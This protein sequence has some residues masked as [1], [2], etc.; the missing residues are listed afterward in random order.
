M[1]KQYLCYIKRLYKSK[2]DENVFRFYFTDQIDDV[3]GENWE[4]IAS[5]MVEPPY[6]DYVTDTFILKTR[7]VDLELLEDSEDFSYNDGADKVI[8]L[9]YEVIED[10]VPYKRLVLHFGEELSVVEDKLFERE[11]GFEIEK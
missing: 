10:A 1:D 5:G 2:K 7:K 4:C 6:V 9:G 8:A 3:V 11:L